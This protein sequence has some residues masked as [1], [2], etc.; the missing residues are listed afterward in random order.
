MEQKIQDIYVL[1]PMQEGM[2]YHYLMDRQSPAYFEQFDLALCG[3]IDQALLEESFRRLVARH[4]ALRT[5]VRYD[6]TRRPVQIVLKERKFNLHFE[7][8]P[9]SDV[10]AFKLAD[11]ERGFDPTKDMLM[12]VSLLQIGPERY[13]LIWSF[14]HIV[15]DGWCL[16]ILYN[17]LL[18]IHEAL[19]QGREPNLDAPVPY[20]NYIAWLA[21]Q[22]KTGGLDFWKKRLDG[23]EN[24]AVVPACP[25]GGCGRQE[26]YRQ[27]LHVF[28]IEKAV[29]EKMTRIGMEHQ[30]TINTIFQTV[31]GIL[32]QRYNNTSDVVFGAVVSGRPSEIEGVEGMVGLFINTVPVRIA[33][34]PDM[35]LIDLLQKAQAEA[36]QGRAHDY[37]PLADIQ[38]ATPLKSDLID[39]ILVFENFPFEDD[40]KKAS[41]NGF[42]IEDVQ[43]FE[44][45]NYNFSMT[46]IPGDPYRVRMSYN[47]FVYDDDFVGQIGAHFLNVLR[48]AAANPQAALK[49][50]EILSDEE[51]KRLLYDFNDT[52]GD[53]P[54]DKAVHELFE[55]QAAQTPESP[56]LI[57][58][59]QKMTYRELN[60]QAN[61]IARLLR[62]KGVKPEAI[63][64]LMVER[65]PAMIAGLLGILKAGGAYLPIDAEFPPD[66]IDD[67]I[68]YSGVEIV[69]SRKKFAGRISKACDMID[70]E[71][72][73]IARKDA[74]NLQNIS[75]PDNL[76][77]VMFTSGSTG[78]PKGVMIE[79]GNMNNFI[80]AMKRVADFGS[81]RKVLALT[82][83]SFDIFALETLL[84]LASG[85]EV[86]IA[87]ED[88]Q[89]DPEAIVDLIR[90]NGINMLQLTPS[91]LQILLSSS[92]AKD[93]LKIP[94]TI[95]IGGEALPLNLLNALRG[96]YA[97]KI[98]NIYGPT[99]TTVWSTVRDV[100][101]DSFIT[102]GKPILNT[103]IYIVDALNR[104]QPAGIFGELLIGGDGVARGY[105][106]NEE[107]TG[108]K[109]ASNPFTPGARLYRTGDLA[110]FLPDGNIEFLGRID[111]QVKIRGFRIELGEIE[112][113]M[114]S[115]PEIDEAVVTER[116]DPS[117][118]KYLCAYFVSEKEIS[119]GEL[120]EHLQ[121]KLPDYML[122]SCFMKID[123]I[124][125]TATG[126]INRKALPAPSGMI[127]TGRAY[128]PPQS[129]LEKTLVS[130]W[131]EVL[132]LDQIGVKDNFF[133]IGGHSVK[134]IT[135]AARMEKALGKAMGLADIFKYPTIRELASRLDQNSEKALKEKIASPSG[136]GEKLSER[137]GAKC[138][139]VQY[140]VEGTAINVLYLPPTLEEKKAEIK[141]WLAENVADDLYPHYVRPLKEDQLLPS[142]GKTID[143]PSFAK[144]MGLAKADAFWVVQ[145]FL[146]EVKKKET[147]FHK[148]ILSGDVVCEYPAT[149]MQRGHLT[150]PVRLAGARLMLKECIEPED[151]VMRYSKLIE[152]QAMLKSVLF[153]RED[154]LYWRQYAAPQ[155]VYL[156]YLDI[157]GFDQ[158]TQL[159]VME[160]IFTRY[161]NREFT[162]TDGLNY[163]F[164]L[165]KCHESLY[166]LYADIDHMLFDGLSGVVL[167]QYLLS[168]PADAKEPANAGLSYSDY[169]RQILCGPQGIGAAELIDVFRLEEFAWALERAAAKIRQSQKTEVEY[170]DLEFPLPEGM[171][172]RRLVGKAFELF[173]VFCRKMLVLDDLP[174]GIVYHGRNYQDKTYF[175]MLGEFVD[176]LPIHVSSQA[177]L[178][179][180][181]ED[182]DKR[183]RFA[184]AHNVNFA[185][186]ATGTGDAAFDAAALLFAYGDYRLPT[187]LFFN[188][189]GEVP[190]ADVDDELNKKEIY[191]KL[192]VQKKINM[193]DIKTGINVVV[194]HTRTSVRIS[195]YV[196]C[197]PA[198][199]D[200]IRAMREEGSKIFKSTEGCK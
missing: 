12:R 37:I 186:L 126:K 128:E 71:S 36:L 13:R 199:D 166:R 98:F 173:C 7:E 69:V 170:F 179:S 90:Q 119:T 51:R 73:G 33:S 116:D 85:M 103:Q 88:Q 76:L 50:L 140:S 25:P 136:I 121:G 11:R 87:R 122:P 31:W 125:L 108:E 123:K 178:E 192:S 16:G 197:G 66:R 65:S 40:P 81:G 3:R 198:L 176:V 14:H 171:D 134:A 27:A 20:K 163:R 181:W 162:K 143:G 141:K 64:G 53:Y 26:G 32:L 59:D 96:V 8:T 180:I 183:I 135:L 106:K 113:R 60:G 1:S 112:S 200:M 42:Q 5:I 109:F 10:E 155:G 172:M 28:D 101:K 147:E 175:H 105:Y 190:E 184:A 15:M 49:A 110:R 154:G 74:S 77:Y 127:K 120:R 157:S 185:H 29:M 115:H 45:V 35:R 23:Y 72:D 174:V 156:P 83:I 137:F 80:A 165:V 63:V 18:H 182:I 129:A 111:A 145:K 84:P 48:Q 142:G 4:D 55:E 67:M 91:R 118:G 57:C 189:L 92:G 187:Y 2:L 117:G 89:K 34:H 17:D 19:R 62:N 56:A 79:H 39:H 43:V 194:M 47:A 161:L 149:P 58:G 94:D 21:R 107:L 131:Q 168:S 6:K 144:A 167:D 139:P 38:S 114:L 132:E 153:D 191:A 102:I 138:I 130:I 100:T 82:T 150:L 188:F 41:D 158:I 44:Q 93:A 9:E 46:V 133:E 95:I 24:K 97:G 70:I 52:K 152:S 146:S 22:D 75:R 61:Q 148:K 104:L 86:H 151:A 159:Q 124:P 196:C 54:R 193:D 78:N 30:I 68:R 164:L 195:T 99:E 177:G 160:L 169:V